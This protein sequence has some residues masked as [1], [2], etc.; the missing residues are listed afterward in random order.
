MSSI[1]V[2]IPARNDAEML[3]TC[4]AAL[5]AQTRQADEIIV[6]D[7][8]SS[9]HT[10]TVA[11]AAGARVVTQPVKGILRATATGFDAATSQIVARIDADSIPPRHWLAR[12][13]AAF[14]ADPELT[15]LSGPGEYYGG[16]RFVRWAGQ[17]FYLGGY[18]Y[19]MP[20][21]LGR[22]PLFGSNFAL[23]R[24]AWLEIRPHVHIGSERIHDDL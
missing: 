13:A 6:V 24:A 23:D 21:L 5:A 4:L 14:T 7:N 15:G 8:G 22:P 9:N 1:S 3:Q 12:I 2:V 19:V 17:T 10:A 20:L 16:N 11:R 18:L